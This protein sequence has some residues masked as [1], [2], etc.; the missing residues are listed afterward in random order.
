MFM[1]C[2]TF[3]AA[4]ETFSLL[5]LLDHGDPEVTPSNIAFNLPSSK[6]NQIRRGM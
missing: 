1:Y 4:P 3:L 2:T 5:V 6:L